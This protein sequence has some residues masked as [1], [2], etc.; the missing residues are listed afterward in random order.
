MSKRYAIKTPR[1]YIAGFSHT[2]QVVQI[3]G[4]P[5]RIKTFVSM[6]SALA[7]I[8]RYADAGYGL[9][10]ETAEVKEV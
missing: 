10:S 7:F 2:H 9:E 5:D 4:L 3:A 6:T 8:N 1:G